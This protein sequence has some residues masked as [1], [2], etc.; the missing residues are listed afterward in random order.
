MWQA[1]LV[2]RN[3]FVVNK[4]YEVNQVYLYLYLYIYIYIYIYQIYHKR[5][6]KKCMK[7]RVADPK[8]RTIF[9]EPFPPEWPRRPHSLSTIGQPT[10]HTLVWGWLSQFPVIYYFLFTWCLS[11]HPANC[12]I[13]THNTS[14]LQG[15]VQLSGKSYREDKKF[16]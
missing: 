4:S 8:N 11:C 5:C 9:L 14:V 12:V 3:K 10:P 13:V 2:I 16:N 1:L 7:Q 15:S 6:L